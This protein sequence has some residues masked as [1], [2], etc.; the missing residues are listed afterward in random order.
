MK[1][2]KWLSFILV[3]VL[4]VGLAAPALATDEDENGDPGPGVPGDAGNA[5]QINATKKVPDDGGASFSGGYTPTDDKKGG[6]VDIYLPLMNRSGDALTDVTVAL[7]N[8]SSDANFPFEAKNLIKKPVSF[9]TGKSQSGIA[10]KETVLF[11]FDNLKIGSNIYNGNYPVSFIA[12]YQQ[13]GQTAQQEFT[14]YVKLAKQGTQPTGETT[15]LP[16][17]Q[18]K[19]VVTS[20]KANPGEIFSGDV[21]ELE[22][23]LT[24]THKSR[25][26]QNARIAFSSEENVL[27]PYEGTSS[28]FIAELRAG[29]SASQKI[30]LQVR[31]DAPAKSHPITLTM[32]YDDAQATSYT[33]TETIT[34][35]IRQQLRVVM[36]DPA[37]PSA[38]M[39]GQSFSIPIS[40]YNLGKSKIYNAMVRL[41]CNGLMPESSYFAGNIE[42]GASANNEIYVT[43]VMGY[44]AGTGD[45]GSDAPEDGMDILPDGDVDILPR[46]AEDLAQPMS[47]SRPAV[48]KP[49]PGGVVVDPGMED[50]GMEVPAPEFN[51]GRI[52]LTYEDEFGEEY[53]QEFAFDITIESY[54]GGFDP[55]PVEPEP[56]P[57]GRNLTWLWVSLGVV[58]AVAVVVT[59]L[60][61][62]AKRRK[63][64]QAYEID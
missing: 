31:P 4:L 55:W 35:T 63:E 40:I 29:A 3:L 58:A 39:D 15:P 32:E 56:E 53:S 19:L 60:V 54:S 50:P 8:A 9:E 49:M 17:H 21:F 36:D 37:I 41:E 18:P 23:E 2:I 5:L 28:L 1:R 61:R 44:I 47:L 45:G 25:G 33:L 12:S 6:T 20:Y 43:P 57:Q 38:V 42:P 62:R 7:Q 48:A 14:V 22:I 13:N 24:N 10:S 11:R 26:I 52:I 51:S 46:E 27:I 34:I 30:K 64:E 59:A 16:Q